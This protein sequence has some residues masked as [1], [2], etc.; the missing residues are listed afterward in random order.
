MIVV[1][2]GFGG[3]W[4]AKAPGRRGLD[5]LLLDRNN[6]HTFFPLLYQVAAAELEPEDIAHPI[7]SAV[8]GLSG[9]T[10]VM[11]EVRGLDLHKREVHT[12]AGT[13]GYD[14]VVLALGSRPRFFGVAG[15]PEH[16]LTLRSLE[17]GVA[18]RNHILSQFE[19]AAV[20]LDGKRRR[21]LLTTVI[22]DGGPTGVE[23]AGALAE[24]IRGP[25][26]KDHPSFDME[27]EASVVLVEAA[28]LLLPG[29]HD[30]LRRYT[31]QRLAAL[32]VEV[33]TNAMVERVAPEAVYLKNASPIEAGTIV[34]TAGVGGDA[35]VAAWGLPASAGGRVE[36]T[37]A[38]HLERHPEAYV[39][40]DLALVAGSEGLP[41]V[42]PVAMQQGTAA[43][44]N[45]LRQIDGQ[46]PMPYRYRDPGTMAVIGR[47]A[48][49]AQV[50]GRSFTGLPAW[51]LWLGVHIMKLIGFRNRLLVLSGWAWDYLFFERAVRLILP[52]PKEEKSRSHP[53]AP[54]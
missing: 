4:A 21:R 52:T 29:F 48:A 47:N 42:A 44:R 54:G 20:E 11:A 31:E 36:V 34:W 18:L 25:L 40:G 1:G 22:V 39:V 2:G 35:A 8:R 16:S 5:V 7:R 13:F 53:G 23:F 28:N 32:G 12:T 51:L 49:V 9:V 43:A 17:E 6:Y 19:R 45:I 24:L 46:T 14:Y 30:P 41:M 27:H 3:L 15:A 50:F 33:R 37:P 26:A 38:L 10:F